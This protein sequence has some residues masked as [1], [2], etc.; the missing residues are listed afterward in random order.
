MSN[1]NTNKRKV[2][3]L[4]YSDHGSWKRITA[5]PQ[6]LDWVKKSKPQVAK[7]LKSK[8]IIRRVVFVQ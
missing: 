8:V 5:E 3:G 1:T 7:L 2:Y 4:F 6:T